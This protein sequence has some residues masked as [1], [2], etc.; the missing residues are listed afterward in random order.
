MKKFALV[1]L[2]SAISISIANNTSFAQGKVK[3]AEEVNSLFAG[4]SGV[5]VYNIYNNTN[6]LMDM[7]ANRMIEKKS[8]SEKCSQNINTIQY[9][10]KQMDG[11]LNKEDKYADILSKSDFKYFKDLKKSLLLLRAQADYLREYVNDVQGSKA[12]FD[13]AK[14]LAW[15]QVVNVMGKQ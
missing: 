12:K 1:C 11:V 5:M 15:K 3:N 7:Y 13:S 9:L 4:V 2:M 14:E 8:V 6:Y 10:I